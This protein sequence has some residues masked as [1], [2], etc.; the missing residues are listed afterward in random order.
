MA[1]EDTVICF[2]RTNERP[3][4]TFSQW[5]RA[6]F[7]LHGTTYVSA[8]QRMMRA[9]AELFGDS[10]TEAAIMAT[11]DPHKIKRLGRQVRGFIDTQWRARAVDI[12]V[13]ANLAKFRQNTTMGNVLCATHPHILAEASPH[14]RI[15]GIGLSAQD[16]RARQPVQW[17]GLN[18][19]GEALMRVRE[20]LREER[21]QVPPA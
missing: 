1:S 17:R 8:E 9:K 6:P 13:E 15:W 18:L 5:T 21:E 3:H 19:L 14:D 20:T 10:V 11:Q 16:P 12:V 2:F 4:G 7:E